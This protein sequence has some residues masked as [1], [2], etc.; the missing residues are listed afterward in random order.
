SLTKRSQRANFSS[1]TYLER[2]MAELDKEAICKRIYRIWK[3]SGLTETEF[4]ELLDPP[5]SYRA[6]QTYKKNRVP[7]DQLGQIA[8]IGGTTKEWLLHGDPVPSQVEAQAD[9]LAD[10]IEQ[11][12]QVLQRL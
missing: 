10:A 5:V 2:L 3:E 11:L 7:Y 4:G 1:A 9:R 6:I 12:V 8:A